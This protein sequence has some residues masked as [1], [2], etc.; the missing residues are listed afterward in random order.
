MS[1]IRESQLV[2]RRQLV[3]ESYTTWAGLQVRRGAR[4]PD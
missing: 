3:V 1:L 4:V 2:R